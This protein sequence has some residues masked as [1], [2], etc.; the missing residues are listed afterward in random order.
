M[1][2]LNFKNIVDD[3]KTLEF[4]HK[5]L[6]SFGVGDIK[7]LLYLTQQ[8]NKQENTTD[9]APIFPLMY[10]IPQNVT[11]DENFITY[12]LNV[13]I[14]D[15]MNANNFDIEVDLW[16]ETLQIAQD[17]LAQYKYSVF[18]SQGNYQTKY[19]LVLPTSITPFSEA[20]DDILVGWN[21]D[22]QIV[23][24]MPLNRC[25]APYNPFEVDENVLYEDTNIF[26]AEDGVGLQ[27]EYE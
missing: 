20:Y 15:I 27:Q 9:S 22:L 23:V 26:T 25:I 19:D 11:Q 24:D 16:S 4:Y 7:Q 13:L 14:C 5:Q 12:R 1:N 6:N 10:C 3:L 21:L 2:Y 17:I 8:N 18:A